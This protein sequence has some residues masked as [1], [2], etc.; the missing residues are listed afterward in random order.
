MSESSES[1]DSSIHEPD[2]RPPF[3]V[4]RRDFNEFA[5]Q[6]KAV[7]ETAICA[8]STK[9]DSYKPTNLCRQNAK[10][11]NVS[12]ETECLL[13]ALDKQMKES[14][15][16]KKKVDEALARLKMFLTRI[17]SGPHGSSTHWYSDH[18]RLGYLKAKKDLIRA[19]LDHNLLDARVYLAAGRLMEIEEEYGRIVMSEAN[20]VERRK[21]FK[22]QFEGIPKL[23]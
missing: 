21:G 22:G 10:L 11:E 12:A 20:A 15:N 6:A 18:E 3:D 23:I 16:L 7:N 19:S 4:L 17:G 2:N 8:V 1:S 9:T 14:A 5:R 13:A